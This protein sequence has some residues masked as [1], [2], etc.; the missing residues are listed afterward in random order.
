MYKYMYVE[1]KNEP[2]GTDGTDGRV[3]LPSSRQCE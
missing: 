1:K 2:D 3:H